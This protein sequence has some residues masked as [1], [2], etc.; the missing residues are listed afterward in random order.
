MKYVIIASVITAILAITA[1]VLD[2]TNNKTDK[3]FLLTVCVLLIV[4]GLFFSIRGELSKEN[5]SKIQTE[6]LSRTKEN[7]E[8]IIKNING[9][10]ERLLVIND[11]VSKLNS[12]LSGVE[13]DL[14]DQLKIFENTLEQT[15]VFEKKVSEQLK[16]ENKRFESEKPNVEVVA[17]LEK[18]TALEGDQYLV[19]FRFRNIGK[20]TAKDFNSQAIVGVVK[21]KRYID[22]HI[23]MKGDIENLNVMPITSGG[24]EIC[25]RSWETISVDKAKNDLALVVLLKYT[26]KDE[27]LNKTFEKIDYYFWYGFDRTGETLVLS[28]EEV[29]NKRLDEYIKDNNLEF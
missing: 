14:T 18:R 25:V 12:A 20:R 15:R 10:L 1:Y 6:S 23:K 7:T 8:L 28:I 17:S 4:S 24:G 16:L 29:F 2:F 3:V 13:K 26:Y 19:L 11:S 5:D 22:R 9:N 27:F 21:D